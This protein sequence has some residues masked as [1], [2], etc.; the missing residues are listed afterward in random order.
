MISER[1]LLEAIKECE[2]QPLTY[3]LCEK[4]STLY[5]VH[6]YLYGSDQP[7]TERKV[8][9]VIE[10]SGE[11]EFLEAANGKE[12]D[13]VFAILDELMNTVKVLHPRVYDS[14]LDQISEL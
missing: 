1:E 6:R 10:T 14:V 4:L 2:D 13:A 9:S 5:T 7:P 12:S 3:P 11:S 8:L